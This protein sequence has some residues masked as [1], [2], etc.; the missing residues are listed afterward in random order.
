MKRK[1]LLESLEFILNKGF[2]TR[3]IHRAWM[4]F[5][6]IKQYLA[7]E[8][9]KLIYKWMLELDPDYPDYRPN[10]DYAREQFVFSVKQAMQHI[11]E[12]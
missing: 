6:K 8:D 9:R 5:N 2:C 1:Y 7:E 3:T 4:E 12:D 10:Y 11:T